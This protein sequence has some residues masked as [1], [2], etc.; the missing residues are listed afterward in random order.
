MYWIVYIKQWLKRSW[1]RI[2]NMPIITQ[3]PITFSPHPNH[4]SIEGS[5]NEVCAQH[6]KITQRSW[7]VFISERHCSERA[8]IAKQNFSRPFDF[9]HD[10]RRS[11]SQLAR[12]QG[13]QTDAVAPITST[14][15]IEHNR[16]WW[17]PK[18]VHCL[19]PLYN[20]RRWINKTG[21]YGSPQIRPLEQS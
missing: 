15:T 17:A 21:T 10:Y 19:Q 18:L 20:S 5:A 7:R 13:H 4:G 8:A 2:I 3:S 9:T 12:S 6:F 11:Q 1:R 14:Y 16:L